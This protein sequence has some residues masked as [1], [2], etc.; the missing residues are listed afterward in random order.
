[1]ISAAPNSS[2]TITRYDRRQVA[3][4]RG[5][6]KTRTPVVARRRRRRAAHVR[7][8]A[9]EPVGAP[10]RLPLRPERSLRGRPG[11]R[12]RAHGARARHQAARRA[13]RDAGPCERR[14]RG[15]R[16][17][18]WPGRR[19]V[20]VDARFPSRRRPAPRDHRAHARRTPRRGSAAAD[21]GDRRHARGRRRDLRGPPHRRRAVRPRRCGRALTEDGGSPTTPWTPRRSGT[22]PRNCSRPST[23]PLPTPPLTSRAVPLPRSD[24]NGASREAIERAG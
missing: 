22:P 8:C 23:P 24:R 17:G 5:V 6:S 9:H 16:S 19:H 14:A 3:G 4:N 11:R 12:G 15:C 18:Q 2:T 13:L 21:R 7:S 10:P 1:M 20:R